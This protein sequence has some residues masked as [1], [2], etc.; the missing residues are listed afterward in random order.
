MTKSLASFK[1]LLKCCP[2][3]DLLKLSNQ[4]LITLIQLFPPKHLP[5]PNSIY[6]LPIYCICCLFSLFQVN[7]ALFKGMH[8]FKSVLITDNVPRA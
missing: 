3:H 8:F 1:S 5:S 7:Y 6:F 4:F 2:P